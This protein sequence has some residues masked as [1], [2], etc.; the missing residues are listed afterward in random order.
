VLC[1]DLLCYLTTYCVMLLCSDLM[2]YVATLILCCAHVRKFV[3]TNSRTSNL[4]GD[5]RCR[6]LLRHCTKSGKVAASIPYDAA[7]G[8]FY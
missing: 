1:S 2:C 5:T 7:I 8:I 6:S 4:Q 3:R